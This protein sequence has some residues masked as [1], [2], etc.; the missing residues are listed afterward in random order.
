MV[1]FLVAGATH[2]RYSEH[3]NSC[4]TFF[5]GRD[6]PYLNFGAVGLMVLLVALAL[7]K[8]QAKQSL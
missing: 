5:L 4:D 1:A 8:A 6:A 3:L 7:Y 2:L